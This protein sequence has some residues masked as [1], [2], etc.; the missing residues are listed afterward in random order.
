MTFKIEDLEFISFDDIGG[1][2]TETK[3]RCPKC[4]EG[5]IVKWKD[6]TTGFKMSV[7]YN[8]PICGFDIEA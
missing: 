4:K 2:E 1:N 3:Y 6:N 5:E 7:W 8:C